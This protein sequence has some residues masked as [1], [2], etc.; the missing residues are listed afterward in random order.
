MEPQKP[1]EGISLQKDFGNSKFYTVPCSCGNPDDEIDFSVEVEDWGEITVNTYTKQK[2][3][4]WDDP[5]TQNKSYDYDKE[6]QYHVNY[7]LRGV[8]NGLVHRLKI[9]WQV[10]VKGYVEY[11]QTTI[12][13]KQQA[14]NYAATLNQAISDLEEFKKNK[15]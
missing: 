15:K 10:W 4:W 14:V 9:T 6:W 12:M 8:L 13:S 2:T 11:S 1:A 5:F 7:W 3:S